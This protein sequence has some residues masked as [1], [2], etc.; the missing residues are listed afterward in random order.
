MSAA[1]SRTVRFHE[2]GEPL[3]V[4]RLEQVDVADPA[5]GQVRVRVAATGL[6]P[7]DW[8]ICRGFQ[9]GSTAQ[10]LRLRRV[11]NGRRDRRRHR[12]RRHRRPGVRHRRRDRAAERR[13]PPTSRSCSN[14][15]PIPDGTRSRR[16][17][18]AADGGDDRGAGPWTCWTS[19]PGTTLLVNGAGGMV[20]YA[21]VQVAR[22]AG[23]RVI[24]TAGPA[25]T[26]DLE[27]FG[28]LVTSYGPG[29]V[30]RVRELAGGAG[31]LRARHGARP[32]GPDGE[33]MGELVRARRGRPD[34]GD[35]GQQSR[36]S[37]SSR[38]AR[39]PRRAAGVRRLPQLRDPRRDWAALRRARASSGCRSPAA[40]RSP[41]GAR[42]SSSVRPGPPTARWC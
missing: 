8:E 7:A 39:Q 26:A 6:N 34:P 22:R 30:A 2:Y 37:P 36:G 41:T 31:R 15:F 16:G 5:P 21:A 20:G 42:L 9:A 24:A 13:A 23:A 28:A 40:S 33:G 12:G 35:D 38:S 17:G 27:G 4:L 25:L 3:D 1:P 19:G 29:M 10:G 14:W 32:T 18:D 11:G